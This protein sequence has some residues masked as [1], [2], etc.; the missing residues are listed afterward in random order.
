MLIY[1]EKD[2]LA[3]GS[4][5]IGIGGLAA[6]DGSNRPDPASAPVDFDWTEPD[7]AGIDF[8]VD[9]QV[10]IESRNA[11]LLYEDGDFSPFEFLAV[12]PS[13]GASVGGTTEVELRPSGDLDAVDTIEGEFGAGTLTLLPA[14]LPRAL[15]RFPLCENLPQAY[16]P[17][18]ESLLPYR[19]AYAVSSTTLQI[20][21]PASAIP[22]SVRVSINGRDERR[23]TRYSDGSLE[24]PFPIMTSDEIE[25]S[26]ELPDSGASGADLFFLSSNLFHPWRTIPELS[27]RADFGVR[28]KVDDSGYSES[29]AESPGSILFA[30]GASYQGESWGVEANGGVSVGTHDTRGYMRL[31]G[32]EEGAVEFGI[33]GRTLF[34]A[35][36]ATSGEGFDAA[37]LGELSFTDYY[38]YLDTGGS[39]LKEYGWSP[40]AD[41][42][43]PFAAG[44]PIGPSTALA[45]DDDI[46]GQ[47]AVL[48]YELDNGEWVGAQISSPGAELDL[49]TA[50]AV[51][52]RYRLTESLS[53]ATLGL[54]LRAGAIAEDLD[55]DGRLD[56]ESGPYD[57][58]FPYTHQ[59]TGD[60]L[61]VGGGGYRPSGGLRQ[62]DPGERGR[63]RQRAPES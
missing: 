19:L 33:S 4:D 49:S 62:R 30:A 50:T 45:E 24:F 31:A 8:D 54:T 41:Q 14:D 6:L 55:G 18:K 3:V 11:L 35:A 9:L 20:A 61:Y 16:G 48:D 42:V 26:Y 7:Y 32:M 39:T 40:P 37:D 1:Y 47:I 22:G 34:P 2:G 17:D 25:V 46:E 15:T 60:V 27:L 63:R 29:Y 13:E 21:V 52:F 5:T 58:G 38:Q 56:E 36:P 57:D 10:T 23:F 12:Y 43:Y 59:P 28:W 51:S 44:N 53:G